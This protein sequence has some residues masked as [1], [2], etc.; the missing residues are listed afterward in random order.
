MG[1]TNFNMQLTD[2]QKEIMDFVTDVIFDSNYSKAQLV[3]EF[4]EERALN[5]L[6]IPST[7]VGRIYDDVLLSA[8]KKHKFDD[9]V[10]MVGIV[11][12]DKFK[13]SIEDGKSSNTDVT[14]FEKLLS[15]YEEKQG[16]GING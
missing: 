5:Y 7:E 9:D 8:L 11:G 10:R 12:V 13:A 16:V 2:T 4:F 1:K 3:L 14:Y 15:T 6:D